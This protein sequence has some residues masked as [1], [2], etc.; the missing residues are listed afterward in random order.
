MATDALI[1]FN[2]VGDAPLTG[3]FIKHN[4]NPE[5]FIPL[6]T[7]IFIMLDE[8]TTDR[9]S[10]SRMVTKAITELSKLTKHCYVA[11]ARAP[12]AED[13][14]IHYITISPIAELYASPSDR[15]IAACI[16]IN[17]SYRSGEQRYFGSLEDYRPKIDLGEY[18][19]ELEEDIDKLKAGPIDPQ[20]TQIYAMEQVVHLESIVEKL[21][22]AFTE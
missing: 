20:T 9:L 6:I 12:I 4:T 17:H 15:C 16:H 10:W 1:V 21:K 5:L 13:F 18:I 19:E 22:Y 7:N 2:H 11:P 8:E 14:M 3:L